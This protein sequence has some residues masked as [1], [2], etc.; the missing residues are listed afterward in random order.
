MGASRFVWLTG[1]GW[2]THGTA[3]Q[4]TI[5]QLFSSR[6]SFLMHTLIDCEALGT[7]CPRSRKLFINPV[8]KHTKPNKWFIILAFAVLAN[9]EEVPE[10][11]TRLDL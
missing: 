7:K 3:A 11:L 4:D 8:K 5:L 2:K 10:T 6:K 1:V 9:S